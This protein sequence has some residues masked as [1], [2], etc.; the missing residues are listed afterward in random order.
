MA[1]VFTNGPLDTTVCMGNSATMYCAFSNVSD[2]FTPTWNITMR[3]NDGSIISSIHRVADIN[4]DPDDGLEYIPDTVWGDNMSP[5]SR[6]VVGPVDEA[7]NQSSYQCVFE[8]AGSAVWSSIG[9]LT[10]AGM[11][12]HNIIIYSYAI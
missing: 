10:V 4:D 6:L 1:L 3:S 8:I 2:Q 9:T 7:Y 11:F 5:D 12:V